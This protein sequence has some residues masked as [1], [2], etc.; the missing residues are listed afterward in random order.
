MAV[1]VL[2]LARWLTPSPDGVG[3]HE[4]LGLPPCGVLAWLG[5]PC[6]ACG[7]TTS[8]AHLARF[9]LIA[10]LRA[11]PLGFPLF[12]LTLALVPL[13]ALSFWRKASFGAFLVRVEAGPWALLFA[14]IVLVTWVAR[15]VALL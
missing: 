8:F 1:V 5:V 3:T 7:L 15:L 14:L 6:P 9:D 13:S 2:G 12:A 10:G 11:Q 4:Q